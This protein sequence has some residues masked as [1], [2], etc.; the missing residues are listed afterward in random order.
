M[1]SD[2]YVYRHIRLDDQTPF[3]VGKGRRH[4]AKSKR[5]RNNYWKSIV[6]KVGYEVELIQ[7]D[8]TEQ[9]ALKKELEFI[10][11]YRCLGYCQANLTIGGGGKAGR[12]SPTKGRTVPD[13]TKKK[14]SKTLMGNVPWN[15][16][17]KLR[18]EHRK[19][20]SKAHI[21]LLSGHRRKVVNRKSGAIY[22]SVTQAARLIGL[23]RTTLTEMLVGRNKNTT[24][25]SYLD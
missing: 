8:L 10:R 22:N 12:R 5:N 2:F 23:K 24:P 11:L 3:Y 21:G 7:T 4:R 14:I 18:Q 6:E 13:E 15:K 9:Q 16:G 19:A 20:L 1:T 17:I 25:F